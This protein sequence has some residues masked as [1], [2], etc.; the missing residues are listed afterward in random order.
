MKV[1]DWKKMLQFIYQDQR[2]KSATTTTK[3]TRAVL[4]VILDF[5]SSK[6]LESI[7][8]LLTAT[9]A[10]LFLVV[11]YSNMVLFL[12]IA[13][14]MKGLWQ[15]LYSLGFIL[16]AAVFILFALLIAAYLFMSLL[17]LF[18]PPNKGTPSK[19]M[20]KIKGHKAF[21]YVKNVW[22]N[23]SGIFKWTAPGGNRNMYIM[24][25]LSLL[26]FYHSWR[27]I[28]TA[29]VRLYKYNFLPDFVMVTAR[30]I[31][32]S[33]YPWIV[34][35]QNWIYNSFLWIWKVAATY[36]DKLW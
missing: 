24:V 34:Y 14:R 20:E 4:F 6:L 8:W 31:Y 21:T 15:I 16:T 32:R 29:N 22:D 26:A 1:L 18:M 30:E 2:Y 5:I 23:F 12:N 11:F 10:Y 28:P 13:M 17:S 33:T 35:V 9:I 7:S 36:I 25:L 27:V 19:T 3:R